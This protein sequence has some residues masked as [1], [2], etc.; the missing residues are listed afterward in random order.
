MV[1]IVIGR[2]VTVAKGFLERASAEVKAAVR[3]A[4]IA[5]AKVVK[6]TAK[7]YCPISPT[8]AQVNAARKAEGKRRQK[9]RKGFHR[10]RPGDLMR[11]IDAKADG[12]GFSVFIPQGAKAQAYAKYIHDQK[13]IKWF[14]RGL[15]TVAKGP[16]ADEKFISRAVR[17]SNRTILHNLDVEIAKAARS[18]NNG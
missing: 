7:L 5:S 15:G 1:E 4:N 16:Q 12:N 13:G 10:K 14:K 11:S 6:K 3:R 2:D 18:L 9:H 17:D 8:Q